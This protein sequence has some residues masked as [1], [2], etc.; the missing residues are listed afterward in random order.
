MWSYILEVHI[1]WLLFYAFYRLSL[2]R[3]TYFYVNRWYLLTTLILGLLLPFV[4]LSQ[5]G[6]QGLSD[7][8]HFVL[9]T[10]HIG[11]VVTT[12]TTVWP[13]Q[14][15][16]LIYWAGAIWWMTGVFIGLTRL[17]GV[18]MRSNIERRKGYSIVW[19]DDAIAPFSFFAL[20]FVSTQHDLQDA[21]GQSLLRH[22]LN[23]VKSLHS[24]D[25]LLV[26]VLQV[27]FW[28]SP[29]VWFYK[30]SL[31]DIHE[32]EA[33]ANTVKSCDLTTYGELLIKYASRHD[34]TLPAMVNPFIQPQLNRR[35]KML[36][37]KP[38]NQIS[39]MKYLLAIP[40]L[41]LSIFALSCK[42]NIHSD[43]QD[44]GTKS[45][46]VEFVSFQNSGDS[47]YLRV[48]QMPQYGTGDKDLLTFL[49]DNIKYPAEAREAGIEGTVVVEFVISANGKVQA[50]SIAKGIGYGCDEEAIR[51]IQSMGSWH[52]GRLQDNTPVAVK[53]TMPIRFRLS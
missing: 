34:K 47:I 45:V 7:M 26:T 39:L 11:S 41:L 49:A 32:F 12:S 51:V 6:I 35:F 4:K 14:L 30:K 1:C 19:V 27:F 17:Y 24:A 40:V 13:L 31:E 33:D 22:E 20:V 42:D 2:S 29:L 8:A 23:H 50:V 44:I 25:K 18:Y 21:E 16:W 36:V 28:F 38:S 37:K 5:E 9:P 3:E 15:F 48:H 43:D 10:V 46:A 53:Y 52:P